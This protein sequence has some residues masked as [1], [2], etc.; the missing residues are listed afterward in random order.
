MINDEI[1]RVG[2]TNQQRHGR[3]L[4]AL[5]ASYGCVHLAVFSFVWVII[6]ALSNEGYYELR[7]LKS[8][9]FLVL[10]FFIV[11]TPLL[12]TYALLSRRR[13][14]SVAVCLTCLVIMIGSFIVL[15]NI[16]WPRLSLNRIIFGVL[17]GGASLT[18]CIYGLWFALVS[19]RMTTRI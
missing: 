9:G 7:E 1:T 19:R 3:I 16:S 6:L 14:A 15:S 8:I 2:Q 12:S 18:I 17:Y 10:T 4:A 5:F 13:W 11:A